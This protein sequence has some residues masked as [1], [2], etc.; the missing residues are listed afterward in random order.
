MDGDVQL[1]IW[2]GELTARGDKILK[3]LDVKADAIEDYL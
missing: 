1:G 2:T 3:K